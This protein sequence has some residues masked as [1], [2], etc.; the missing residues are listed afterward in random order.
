MNK[1][2]DLEIKARFSSGMALDIC[3]RVR[4]RGKLLKTKKVNVVKKKNLTKFSREIN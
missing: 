2:T 4:P 3:K 1:K